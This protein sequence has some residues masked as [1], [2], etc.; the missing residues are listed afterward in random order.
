MRVGREGARQ[1]LGG[2]PRAATPRDGAMAQQ[3][4]ADRG[5]PSARLCPGHV[6][7]EFPVR[8]QDVRVLEEEEL[9][10]PRP[11][12]SIQNVEGCARFRP[13]ATVTLKPGPRRA[14]HPDGLV[15]FPRGGADEAQAACPTL[16]GG[17]GNVDGI[18]IWNPP[19]HLLRGGIPSEPAATE[20]LPETGSPLIG[21]AG[22]PGRA[23]R[24][25]RG[26]RRTGPTR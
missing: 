5:G 14:V 1:R 7:V 25:R 19:W 6:Q 11:V 16:H 18:P 23:I 26:S 10:L 12:S 9:D 15:E 21:Q 2:G 17:Q 13:S 3:R 20:G 22:P 4:E 24:P 8:A